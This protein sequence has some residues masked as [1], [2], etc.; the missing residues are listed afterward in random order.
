MQDI[1]TER[2]YVYGTDSY[3]QERKSNCSPL[4]LQNVVA[5]VLMAI[6]K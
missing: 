1:I 5:S 4:R 6:R 2:Q 3:I